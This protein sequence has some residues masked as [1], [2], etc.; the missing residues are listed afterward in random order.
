MSRDDVCPWHPKSPEALVRRVHA[1]RAPQVDADHTFRAPRALPAEAQPCGRCGASIVW[2]RTAARSSGPGG[3]A[4]PLDAVEDLG[5][6]VAV[7]PGAAGRLV[8][9]VL[10][11]GET[12]AR[13]AEYQAMPHFATCTGGRR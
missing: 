9:R 6:N 4:M 5:G 7:T 1:R 8:A 3:K 13:P 2:A 10:P 12:P 11:K